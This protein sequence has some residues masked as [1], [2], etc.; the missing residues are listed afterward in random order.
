MNNAKRLEFYLDILEN[1]INDINSYKNKISKFSP[2]DCDSYEELS[3]SFKDTL[4]AIAFRFNKIQSILGEKVF[5]LFL[6]ESGF[7]ASNKSFLEM[8][9]ELERVE[10]LKRTEWLKLR[11]IRNKVSQEYP[12]E[13]YEIIDNL[14][15]MIE[16]IETFETIYNKIK[17]K[18]E[19][20]KK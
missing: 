11:E 7:D 19:T 12:D 6:E 8:L 5:K 18:Y 14:N 10:I 20:I 1:S 13:L 3:Y 9:A 2:L 4:D 17:S 16:N 15:K